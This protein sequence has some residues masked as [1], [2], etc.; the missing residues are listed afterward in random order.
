ML[1]HTLRKIDRFD[2]SMDTAVARTAA[3]L[4]WKAEGIGMQM[5][6]NHISAFPRRNSD[7]AQPTALEIS[8]NSIC[9]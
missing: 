6:F 8:T 9:R 3:K 5:T 2:K 4:L 7:Q 1:K